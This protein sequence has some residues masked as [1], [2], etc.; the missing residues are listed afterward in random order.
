MASLVPC[1]K[2]PLRNKCTEQPQHTPEGTTVMPQRDHS[3]VEPVRST[4][5][6]MTREA[7][8]RVDHLPRHSCLSVWSPGDT[9]AGDFPSITLVGSSTF[10]PSSPV[11]TGASPIPFS[12]CSGT[13]STSIFPLPF[14]GTQPRSSQL[15][16]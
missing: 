16:K 8:G 2:P 5:A 10:F 9:V 6:I 4:T 13:S 12:W 1:N 15:K 11:A 3:P 14:S 7:C